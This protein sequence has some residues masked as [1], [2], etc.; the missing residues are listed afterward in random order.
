MSNSAN[1]V[2]AAATPW[3]RVVSPQTTFAL[4]CGRAFLKRPMPASYSLRTA[5]EGRRF[6]FRHARTGNR[7]LDGI[8][9][10]GTPYIALEE[11]TENK[12]NVLM[13]AYLP[14]AMFLIFLAFF[15]T[16][17]TAGYYSTAAWLFAMIAGLFIAWRVIPPNANRAAIRHTADILLAFCGMAAAWASFSST[18]SWLKLPLLGAGAPSHWG[19]LARYSCGAIA[20]SLSILILLTTRAAAFRGPRG[21]AFMLRD[22]VATLLSLAGRVVI[23]LAALWALT[24]VG[25]AASNLTVFFLF[26]PFV[27]LLVASALGGAFSDSASAQPFRRRFH[28][29]YVSL[30]KETG[31]PELPCPL[32]AIRLPDD[33]ASLAIAA[34]LIARG[35]ADLFSALSWKF[36]QLQ[37][38]PRWLVVSLVALMLGIV[39]FEV[40]G[41]F[42]SGITGSFGYAAGT[43]LGV[44]GVCFLFIGVGL[45]L[46][47]CLFALSLLT[48]GLLALAIG[49]DV[50]HMLPAARFYCE[51]LPRCVPTDLCRFELQWVPQEARSHLPLRHFL[52]ELEPVRK[53]VAEWITA[54]ASL[55]MKGTTDR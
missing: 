8:L 35:V 49:P 40:H 46:S 29:F 34:S 19:Q 23:A 6:Q 39:A 16:L 14:T 37:K 31:T 18:S 15:I 51:P 47:S 54:K 4:T 53:R 1:F 44:A 38:V 21:E 2:G 32:D 42:A 26:W 36:A 10:L 24:S 41:V 13:F 5:M 43:I 20:A 48:I 33:E 17:A 25:A 30:Q 3:T 28:D 27:S 22:T 7:Q 12:V 11:N 9:S 45:F 50:N 52:H 55:A